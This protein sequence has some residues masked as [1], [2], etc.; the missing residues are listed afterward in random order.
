MTKR[1]RF[2][3][4]GNSSGFKSGIGSGIGSGLGLG[5]G[6]EIAHQAVRSMLGGQAEPQ[7]ENSTQEGNKGSQDS[8][9]EGIA[10]KAMSICQNIEM[11][12]QCSQIITTYR[13]LCQDEIEPIL[14]TTPFKRYD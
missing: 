7:Q 1:N 11:E 14:D 9:C 3:S 12:H 4:R 2:S 6:S 13:M 8:I 10:K 5:A